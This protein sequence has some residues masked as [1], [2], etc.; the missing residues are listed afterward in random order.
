MHSVLKNP[1]NTARAQNV[2]RQLRGSK[3]PSDRLLAEALA[4]FLNRSV[5]REEETWVDRIEALRRQLAHSPDKISVIDFGLPRDGAPGTAVDRG[6]AQI[7]RAAATPP[8]WGPLMFGLIRQFKPTTCLE[9]GT[10]LG[11][12]AA[13]LGAALELNGGGTLTTLE[14]APAVAELAAKNLKQLGIHRVETVVGRFQD[15]L[16][17]VLTRIGSVDFAFIDGHHDEHATQ[18]YFE[19]ILP[20]LSPNAVVAFDDISWSSGMQAAWKA[21]TGNNQVRTAVD[22][23]KVGICLL[24]RNNEVR[25]HKSLLAW[26]PSRW[27]RAVARIAFAS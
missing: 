18:Q 7:C 26:Q 21:I 5:S 8:L 20:H 1:Y 14:G 2:M 13:Y 10:S 17:G 3:Q 9:L 23:S 15:T 25:D 11:I 22:L 27:Q 12:S 19:Q 4:T 16:A 6:V 24:D